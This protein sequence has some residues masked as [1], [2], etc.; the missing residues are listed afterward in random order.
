[1]P[2]PPQAQDD[3]GQWHNGRKVGLPGHT[4]ALQGIEVERRFGTYTPD[5]S[6][7][8]PSGILLIEIRVTHAVDDGK[9]TRVDAHGYRMVEIDLSHLDRNTPHDLA[10]ELQ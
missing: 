7:I 4:V 8:D 9:A 1:M 2:N 6:A 3:G 10:V 5:V